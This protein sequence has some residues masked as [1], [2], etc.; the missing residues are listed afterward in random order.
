MRSIS[1]LAVLLLAISLSLSAQSGD[2]GADKLQAPPDVPNTIHGCLQRS[3]F[4][5][6][7]IEDSGKSLLL[8]GDTGKLRH[9]GGHQVEITGKPTV[10]TINTT[11]QW[12]ASTVEEIP[13]FEVNSA[14]LVSKA[15]SSPSH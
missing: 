14:K 10:K 4:Q 8:T 7:L 11:E 5:Y 1:L 15:C 3:G 2:P 9:L 13:A 6:N 12:A